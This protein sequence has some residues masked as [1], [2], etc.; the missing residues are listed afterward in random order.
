[1][2]IKRDD[3]TGVA[4]TGNKIRKLQFTLAKAIHCGYDTI[5]TD[6]A[7]YSNHCRT[8]AVSCA[9]LGLECHLLLPFRYD[10][11]GGKEIEYSGNLAIMASAGAKLYRVDK[12]ITQPALIADVE[13]F[14]KKYEIM[15]NLAVELAKKG[16]KPYIVYRGGSRPACI[17]V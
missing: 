8:T 4:L 14:K 17:W 11:N 9:Q 5:I 10:E 15:K 6:G 1:M 12:N 2:F 7:P 16:K 13:S 3:L